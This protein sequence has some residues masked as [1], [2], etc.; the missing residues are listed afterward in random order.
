MVAIISACIATSTLMALCAVGALVERKE[1]KMGDTTVRKSVV[2][3]RFVPIE[4][5]IPKNSTEQAAISEYGLT[6]SVGAL[7]NA[8]LRWRIRRGKEQIARTK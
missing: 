1:V 3:L 6:Q 7:N 5:F 2:L 8:G 4:E